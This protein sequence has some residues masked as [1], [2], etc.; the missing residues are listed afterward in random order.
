MHPMSFLSKKVKKVE[1][2]NS[3]NKVVVT[4]KV[5]RKQKKIVKVKRKVIAECVTCFSIVPSTFK[6]PP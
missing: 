6:L 5:K 1:R 3:E 4:Q 2:K